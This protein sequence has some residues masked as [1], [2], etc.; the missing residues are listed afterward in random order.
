M[1]PETTSQVAIPLSK[2]KIILLCLGSCAFVAAAA[3]MLSTAKQQSALDA[4]L[5]TGVAWAGMLFFGLC[6]AYALFKLF[7]QRAGLIIDAD[8]IIDNS[9]AVAAGRIVWSDVTGVRVCETYGQAFLVIEVSDP[10]K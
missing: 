5:M 8:G 3:W 9:S 7:D 2:R 6:G 10:Q 1:V 4:T